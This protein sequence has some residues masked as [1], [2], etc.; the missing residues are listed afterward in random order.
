MTAPK[1][2]VAEDGTELAYRTAGEG[3]A[4]LCLPGL[5]RNMADFEALA[6]RLEQRVLV[7]RMDYRGRG[8]SGRA[9]PKSYTVAQEAR[10]ACALADHL[11][12]QRFAV[13]GTSRGG[14]IAMLLAATVP[15]RLSGAVLNDIG[16]EI[17]PEGLET[18]K[19]YIGTRP[20][21]RTHAEAG[22]AMARMM[23]DR[24]PGVSA[25]RWRRWAEG[26][27]TAG[28]DGLELSYDP[29][30]REAVLAA[31]EAPPVDAWP[32]FDS[33]AGKPL[34]LVRGARSDILAKATADEMARRRPDMIRV[35]LANRGHVPF[36]DESEALA[37][38][39]RWLDL[40]VGGTP[41]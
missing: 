17:A 7:V 25:E 24:F 4:V 36:L 3:P 34:V 26:Y 15:G 11:G 35:E 20:G 13:I 37:A 38:I 33:L 41:E 14:L 16:P 29:R 2:F 23:A 21:Y 30:L 27:W 18:I 19:E 1:R 8:A 9:D 22:E 12:L 5:T 31:A 32:L 39:D 28:P 6:Q 10:D 40:L